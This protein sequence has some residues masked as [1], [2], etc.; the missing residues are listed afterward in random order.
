MDGDK[1][2]TLA[3][4]RIF[5][6]RMAVANGLVDKL[7]TLNDALAEA[8]TLAGLKAD[9]KIDLQILPKPKN[10]F[11]Q[12]FE[13]SSAD[14]EVRALFGRAVGAARAVGRLAASEDAAAGFQPRP[15]RGHDA[16]V[17]N[18]NSLGSFNAGCLRDG[19]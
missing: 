4:G 17:P 12:M 6:G 1:I 8:K 2:E 9:D 16:A 18:R 19:T 11:E 13:G 14:T 3:Q 15:A 10:F 7:G 5:T